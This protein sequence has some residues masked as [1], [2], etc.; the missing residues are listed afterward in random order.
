LATGEALRAAADDAAV[1]CVVLR[2]AGAMFPSGMDLAM[3]SAL[4]DAP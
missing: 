3:V 1:R 2:G 4:A